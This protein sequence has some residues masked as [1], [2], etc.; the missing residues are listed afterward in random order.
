[1]QENEA[2]IITE[3]LKG[4]QKAYEKLTLKHKKAIYHIIY[5]IVHDNEITNDLVQ[6][7][8]M[9]AFI[10]L[11]S[12]RPEFRFSTWIYKIAANCSIDY[13]RKKRINALSLDQ[14]WESKNGMVGIE[15]ADYSYHPERDLERKERRFSIEE[16]I[17]SLP[18]K[19][20]EV[21][22]YRHKDDKS[23]EEIA[24]LLNIPVGTV[25]ARIFRARELLKKKLKELR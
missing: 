16:A 1:M 13:L 20:R 8:F 10:N 19:Y 7:T 18:D 2:T 12:Y 21:I 14:K 15:V 22:I 25:K 3:A 5:K 23:Y 11:K 24:D 9:K 6:E 17:T 4:S